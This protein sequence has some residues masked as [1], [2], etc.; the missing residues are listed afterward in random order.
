VHHGDVLCANRARQNNRVVDN[1]AVAPSSSE[2][3][4]SSPPR[5]IQLPRR[6]LVIAAVV[7]LVLATIAGACHLAFLCD[8][9]YIHFR[10]AANAHAGHGLVWNAPPFRPVEG[11]GFLW[12]L[13]LWSIWSWFGIEPPD[14]ANPFSIGCGVLELLV[15]AAAALRLC[16]RD[17]TRLPESVGLLALAA[18]ACNRTFLQWM[19]GGLDTALFNLPFVAWVL[20]ACRAPERCRGRWLLVWSSFAALAALTRPDGLTLVCATIGV[21]GVSVLQRRMSWLPALKGLS[22]LLAVMAQVL[23]RFSFYGEWLPNTYYAKVVAAWPEA[24]LRYFACFALENGAWLWFPVAVCWLVVECRRAHAGVPAL[25][26]GTLRHHLPAVAAVL[27]TLFNAGYYLIA[28]GGDHFEYRVLS[29]LVPLGVLGCVAMAARIGNGVRLP[30]AIAV[31]LALAAT[32]G[33]VH[34]ALTRQLPSHGFKPIAPQLPAIVRPLARWY[35]HQQAWLFF[36]F[37][38]TRC[39]FQTMMLQGFS[40]MFGTQRQAIVDPP[41]PFPIVAGGA[42]GM[43]GWTLPD[44]AVIDTLGLNDWVVAR[45]PTPQNPHVTRERMR[46][47]AAAADGNGDGSLDAKELRV[48]LSQAFAADPAGHG[49]EFVGTILI[50][51][52]GDEHTGRIALEDAVGIGDLIGSRQMAHERHAPPAYVD[53]FDPNVTVGNGAATVRPRKVPMTAERVHA[54]ETEWEQKVRKQGH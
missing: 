43:L 39:N 17:G 25:V 29:Q 14:A 44:C 13:I 34:H 20:H 53:A 37:I 50:Q 7:V 1:P 6:P 2:A 11:A 3:G 41:D 54:I 21:A 8:D 22:P 51:I 10:Y 5:G 9:A 26:T 27:V 45:L 33:W 31:G 30:I 35:D 40:A 49:G 18:I 47:V 12:P 15:I 28:V 38:G 46:E 23:W 19:T 24:G 4:V 42:V 48:A 32:P 36:R 52:L 16:R